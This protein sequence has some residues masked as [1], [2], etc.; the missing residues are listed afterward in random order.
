MSKIFSPPAPGKELRACV[1][2]GRGGERRGGSER[3][4]DAWIDLTCLTWSREGQEGGGQITKG[5]RARCPSRLRKSDRKLA[6]SL[7]EGWKLSQE[8]T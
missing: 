1:M 2:K 6:G 8:S 7:S 5:S 3:H 4:F